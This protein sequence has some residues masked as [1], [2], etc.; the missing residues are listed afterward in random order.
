MVCAQHFAMYKASDAFDNMLE[1]QTGSKEVSA[2]LK[3]EEPYYSDDEWESDEDER[4]DEAFTSKFNLA[5]TEQCFALN[6]A[7]DERLNDEN[8]KTKI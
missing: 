5:Q 2:L 3:C 4:S 7:M 6:C 8:N 1:A